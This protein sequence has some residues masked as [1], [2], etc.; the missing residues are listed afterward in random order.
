M[1]SILSYKV[2][3]TRAAAAKKGP[4]RWLNLNLAEPKG[5]IKQVSLFFYEQDPSNLGFVNHRT[6]CVM[7]NL[8]LADFEPIYHLVQSEKPAFTFWRT[9]PEEDKLI[10][11]DVSTSEEP[12]GEGTPDRSP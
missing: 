7:A 8:K 9:D 11:I 2:G 4:V 1:S 5:E 3:V 12:L 6:G 10:S